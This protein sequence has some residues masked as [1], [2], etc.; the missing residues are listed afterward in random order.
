MNVR[1]GFRHLQRYR[2]I[3]TALM[4]NGFG[5]LVHELGLPDALP[6]FRSNEQQDIHKKTISERIRLIL[7]ELGPTFVK[8][9]QIASTRPDLLPADMIAELKH[10]QDQVVP[11]SYEEVKQI[12]EDELGVPIEQLYLTF[13][14]TPMASASIG[15]VHR[16]QLHDGTV[17]AVKVQR[18]RIAAVIETDLDMLAELARLAEKRLEW[19]RNYRL[20]EIVEELA[21]SLQAELDY[22]AEARNGV[23]F[24][25]Q[26]AKLNHVRVPA[27]YPDYCSRKVLTME[28]MSG[29]KLSE[30][31]RLVE[32]GYDRTALAQQ[33]AS[34]ILHQVLIEGL[35]H[36]DPHPG[37]VMV[38][39]NGDLGLMD[40]GMVGRLSSEMKQ[41]FAL[42]V[43]G[44][45]NQSSKT[46]LR[47][48]F[49][50]GIVPDDVDEAALR[51]EVDELRDKYYDVPLSEVSIGEAV[52]DLFSV[53]F[54]H[55]IRMPAELTLLGKT[56]LT[57]EGVVT[58]L[59]PN[60]SIIDIAEPYGRKLFR[61]QFNPVR[62]GRKWLEEMPDYMDL[63]TQVPLSLKSL[64]TLLQRGKVRVEITAPE[65]NAFLHKM[66]R[67]S[68]KMSLS[69]VLLSL[70]II[71]AG[72]IIGSSIGNQESDLW[73]FPVIKVGL[74][75]AG[76]L[77]VWL[78]YAIMK[79]G[80]F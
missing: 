64:S 61:E 66:D 63:L 71:M 45:R 50:M 14:Q 18:P 38:L 46:I 26:C 57:M 65:L 10:L 73:N 3:A 2:K 20:Q 69:I 33:L 8:L 48:V 76:A 34:V 13:D 35:F 41:H 37:N 25:A 44:L 7:E 62:I 55:R 80:R 52:N 32:A 68:N 70:S 40:F 21:R 29:I 51:A 23:K 1:K 4:R 72:L 11:F 27:L 28:F 24:A 6:L 60:F 47:A 77:V 39:E 58:E 59:D 67:I 79:S 36:G 19:A 9:G 49:K 31:G 30:H 42:L 15:Q 74:G 54:R 53:A 56:L 78:I 5:Y 16:A 75:I 43:I 22:T 17:V 12:V